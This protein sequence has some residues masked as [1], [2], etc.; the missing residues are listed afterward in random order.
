[1]AIQIEVL[2]AIELF[3]RASVYPTV[4]TDPQASNNQQSLFHL[5]ANCPPSART[6]DAIDHT[7]QKEQVLT[8]STDSGR[9][10]DLLIGKEDELLICKLL[11][12][13]FEFTVLNQRVPGWNVYD[14]CFA[15]FGFGGH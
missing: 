1:M 3:L 10:V 7:T 12:L 15:V 9:H 5:Q 4:R 6:R 11:D 8:L 2:P 14:D 13:A